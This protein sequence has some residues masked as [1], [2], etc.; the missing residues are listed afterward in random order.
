[1]S[2]YRS[3]TKQRLVVSADATVVPVVAFAAH[4]NGCC[5]NVWC[6]LKHLACCN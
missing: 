1:M 4:F 5:G 3:K 2:L 6:C